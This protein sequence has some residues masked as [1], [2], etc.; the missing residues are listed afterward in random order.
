MLLDKLTTPDDRDFYATNAVEHGWSRNVLT[1]HIAT[2]LRARIGAAASSFADQLPGPD[3]D[4][5]QQL[6]R[7]PFVF[8]FLA[9]TARWARDG[10]ETAPESGYGMWPVTH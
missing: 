10:R 5:A 7:D 4:F 6:V 3:S 8:D 9:L 1:H 2:N